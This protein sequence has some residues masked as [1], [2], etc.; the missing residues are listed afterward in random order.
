MAVQVAML[1]LD[2]VGLG[3]KHKMRFLKRC[4]ISTEVMIMKI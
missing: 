1:T 2:H 3:R 4:F